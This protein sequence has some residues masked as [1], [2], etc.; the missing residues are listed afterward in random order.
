MRDCYR[1]KSTIFIIEQHY[2]R[3]REAKTKFVYDP[4][5]GIIYFEQKL[6]ISWHAFNETPELKVI[7]ITF[8]FYRVMH[9]VLFFRKFRS[10]MQST[11]F[12]TILKTLISQL[13]LY[14]IIINPI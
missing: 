2:F 6:P 11:N 3:Y 10:I 12:K 8:Q 5:T 7:S 4:N 1:T 14:I 9:L 13:G